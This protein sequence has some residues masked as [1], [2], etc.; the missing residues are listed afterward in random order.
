MSFL[1]A[2]VTLFFKKI[3]ATRKEYESDYHAALLERMK[4]KDKKA[5]E[6]IE[7]MTKDVEEENEAWSDDE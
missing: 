5:K 4:N 3:S 1:F 2:V 6:S 7:K